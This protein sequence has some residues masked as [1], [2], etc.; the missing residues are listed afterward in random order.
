MKS[1]GQIEHSLARETRDGVHD[2]DISYGRTGMTCDHSLNIGVATAIGLN[3]GK[4][5]G[6]DTQ[7]AN[8]VNPATTG[9]TD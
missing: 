2:I 4:V 5:Q 8:I 1:D 6:A 9:S 7:K 3:T